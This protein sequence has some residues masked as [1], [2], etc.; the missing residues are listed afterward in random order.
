MTI[1]ICYFVFAVVDLWVLTRRRP[2]RGRARA[3][4]VLAYVGLPMAVL[5]HSITAWIFGLQ[6]S[7]PWWN[8]AL[9]APLFVVSAIL[10][11]TALVTLVALAAH[12]FDRLQ[13]PEKT[14]R[15]LCALMAVA[16]AIDLFLV[17]SDYV[18]HHLGQRPARAGGARPDPARRQLAVAVLARVGRRRD[19]AVRAARRAAPA[20]TR[21]A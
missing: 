4:R 20:R 10:S 7:R 21:L 6:I 3:L 19:R 18:T 2:S 13:V 17:G 15:A 1:I 12:R 11:G 16:L 14:W 9:M 5:L 8:T